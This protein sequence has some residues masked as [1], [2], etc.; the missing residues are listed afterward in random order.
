MTDLVNDYFKR[1]YPVKL[2]PKK[3]EYSTML[4]GMNRYTDYAVSKIFPPM[5]CAD[6]FSMS[7][8][9]HAGTY[10]RPRDDFAK[11]YSAVEVGFPSAREEL[12]M[13]F[14]DGGEDT[15]PTETVYGYVPLDIIEQ[16]VA[17]HG[18]LKA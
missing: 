10:S 9:G 1:F 15:D 13:P 2:D 17:K 4:G 12:L 14:I 8:Q 16:V 5:T 18:G 7:V 11:H 6:G 3:W